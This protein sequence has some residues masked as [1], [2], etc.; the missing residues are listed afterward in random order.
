MDRLALLIAC[1]ALWISFNKTLPQINLTPAIVQEDHTLL[2]N[3]WS[4]VKK[5]E[6]LV[7]LMQ[8]E[9][10]A[11]SKPTSSSESLTDLHLTQ[12]SQ[13]APPPTTTPTL[14]SIV[15]TKTITP[16][17]QPV[18]TSPQRTATQTFSS[19]GPNGCRRGLFGRR[20]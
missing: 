9:R 14:P 17:K 8:A 2:Q 12:I 4:K 10:E 1:C 6:A 5:I 18:V 15:Q 16:A 13:P 3:L 7:T 20:R 19:C 11:E